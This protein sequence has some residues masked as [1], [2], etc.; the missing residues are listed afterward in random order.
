M[1]E[2]DIHINGKISSEDEG[3]VLNNVVGAIEFKL[4]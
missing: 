4:V 3:L 2:L 1:Q